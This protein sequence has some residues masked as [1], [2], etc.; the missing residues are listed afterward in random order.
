MIN[1]HL[2]RALKTAL[3]FFVGTVVMGCG[4][5][6]PV[7]PDPVKPEINV[8]ASSLEVFSSGIRVE[9]EPPGGTFMKDVVFTTTDKWTASVTGDGSTSWVTVRP[10]SG[11]S[12]KTTMTVTVSTNGSESERRAEVN[13]ACGS[14]S[15]SFSV[16]QEG[17][18]PVTSEPTLFNV[19]NPEESGITV[20]SY[21]PSKRELLMN[22]PEDRIP[23]VG[24]I[25]CS[26]RSKEAPFGFLG[27]VG[28]V[29]VSDTRAGEDLA[30]KYVR[31]G[32]VTCSLYTLFQKLG[33][34]EKR[35]LSLGKA[36]VSFT[37]D[38][39]HSIE[40][41]KD[42][43]GVDLVS[44]HLPIKIHDDVKI[45][46]TYEVSVPR[47]SVYVDTK[48]IN[49]VF[50]YDVVIKE[51]ELLHVKAG[52]NLPFHEN[53]EVVKDLGWDRP[54]FVHVYDIQLG[55]IPVVIT[56]QY[57]MT[58]PY[59]ISLSAYLDM[60]IHKRVTYHHMG[61]YYYCATNTMVPLD[62]STSFSEVIE[63]D[64]EGD[65][66]QEYSDREFS[67]T[68]DGKLSVGVDFG[69][70]VGLYG[71][72]LDDDGDIST[73]LNYLSAG[74][75]GG[76]KVSNKFSLGGLINADEDS[77]NGVRIIDDLTSTA[78][79]YGKIW[80]TAIS[81]DVLGAEIQLTAAKDW[82]FYKKELYS[83]FF[84]PYYSKLKVTSITR[85]NFLNVTGRKH[86]PLFRGLLSVFKETDY[87]LCLESFD[88]NDYRVFSLAG[89]PID[90]T[91]RAFSFD[92]PLDV[93]N[94]RRNVKYSVYPYSKVT[95][96][97]LM[98]EEKMVCRK[99]V[100][101]TISDDGQ[102]STATIDDVPGEQL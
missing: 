86:K 47:C 51:S 16:V 50:G 27:E 61:G 100:S 71:G 10:M 99:G 45:D 60:D 21:D 102:L 59:E 40:P 49:L 68:L 72:N 76:M 28:S 33:V 23:K 74:A 6:K 96:F 9:A 42:K 13:I 5:E 7:E 19:T 83:S 93:S 31:A 39:G 44:I 58:I 24:D 94:L 12:G 2:Y 30:Q 77:H 15:K 29:T 57:M 37:D 53:G 14:V 69:W 4:E 32:F 70:S 92:I 62:G 25:I 64:D 20:V 46:Y 91:T 3:F 88:G 34:E 38:A 52:F 55:P 97:L 18:A 65:Y 43:D 22:V 81:T 87:G 35:W 41:I 54:S 95:N 90:D 80:G 82:D 85:Q 73:G 66:Q 78:S 11:A 17:K 101:F 36:D 98:N 67:A 75:N 84:F 8:D 1:N 48:T 56:T 89:H 79:A 26:G 63:G